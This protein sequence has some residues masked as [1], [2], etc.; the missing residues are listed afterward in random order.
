MESTRQIDW[1][2]VTG[3]SLIGCM[4]LIHFVLCLRKKVFHARGSYVFHE[5]TP[6]SFWVLIVVEAALLVI[7]FGGMAMY[8]AEGGS[9]THEPVAPP[10]VEVLQPEPV[11][12]PPLNEG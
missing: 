3:S 5:V 6:K 9:P 2:F 4:I 10:P 1:G 7:V 8:L 12:M 11:T